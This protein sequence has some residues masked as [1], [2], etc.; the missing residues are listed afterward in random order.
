MKQLTDDDS[1]TI[2]EE[3]LDQWVWTYRI[4]LLPDAVLRD[5]LHQF[6]SKQAK[7]NYRK[8]CILVHPDK[9]VHDNASR[10][11]QKLL[12]VYTSSSNV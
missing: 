8:L 3:T 5:L 4:I 11:F 7:S 10:A 6:G 2:S 9:N 1:L 12:R